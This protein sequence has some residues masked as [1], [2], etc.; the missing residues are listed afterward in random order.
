MK[1]TLLK[2]I[3]KIGEANQEARAK[4]A[5]IAEERGL[6]YCELGLSGCLHTVFLAPAHRHKRGWYKGNAELLADPY[7]W[8]SACVNC[9]SVIEANKDLTEGVFEKLRPKLSTKE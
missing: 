2:R 1:R 7:E 5:E 9:H 6:N 8:I 3:G 4:I